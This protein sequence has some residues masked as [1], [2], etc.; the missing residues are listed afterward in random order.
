M[1][2]GEDGVNLSGRE[3]KR[4]EGGELRIWVR[5]YHENLGGFWGKSGWSEPY[6]IFSIFI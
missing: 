1:I 4:S 3:K 5:N 2:W 6:D